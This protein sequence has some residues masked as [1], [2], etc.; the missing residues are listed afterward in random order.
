MRPFLSW[1]CKSGLSNAMSSVTC[2]LRSNPCLLRQA[3]GSFKSDFV[4]CH[5]VRGLEEIGHVSRI[6]QKALESMAC[7]NYSLLVA[8]AWDTLTLT[9]LRGDGIATAGA[10]P[11]Q[12]P[13]NK[14]PWFQAPGLLT[15]QNICPPLVRAASS[16]PAGRECTDSPA[17]AS[18][19]HVKA[20]PQQNRSSSWTPSPAPGPCCPSGSDLL[21][22]LL[23]QKRSSHAQK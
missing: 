16:L 22:H 3:E 2:E 11:E 7:C 4:L 5:F 10:L 9:E 21:E 6:P 14:P 8:Q 13:I 12:S 23:P 17:A 15:V 1:R 18:P 19:A 20:L